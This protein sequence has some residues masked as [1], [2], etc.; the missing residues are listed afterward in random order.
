MGHGNALRHMRQTKLNSRRASWTVWSSLEQALSRLQNGRSASFL[1][2]GGFDSHAPPPPD[3]EFRT[4]TLRPFLR[5]C[6]ALSE[7]RHKHS[8]SVLTPDLTPNSPSCDAIGPS[9]VARNSPVPVRTLPA[10]VIS[11]A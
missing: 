8:L 10:V 3:V 1:V 5:C 11:G 2:E 9:F 4:E 7:A 6:D